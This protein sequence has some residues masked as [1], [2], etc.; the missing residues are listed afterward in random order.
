[1]PGGWQLC[2]QMWNEPDLH[3]SAAGYAVLIN[4]TAAAVRVRHG[5]S[6]VCVCIACLCVLR[7]SVCTLLVCVCFA[8]LWV[9]RVSVCVSFICVCFTCLCV[10]RLS[11]CA[12]LVCV[13]AYISSEIQ[14]ALR[15]RFA[16]VI[17]PSNYVAMVCHS[18]SLLALLCAVLCA[19]RVVGTC[20]S[21]AHPS[22]TGSTGDGE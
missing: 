18:V 10:L 7:L 13:C 21:A 20:A 17:F 1:M 11:M 14:R 4:V 9:L 16:F 12:S 2:T 3:N 8:C 15:T 19:S 6:R 5:A 22:N